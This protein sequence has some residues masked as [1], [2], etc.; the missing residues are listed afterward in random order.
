MNTPVL[1]VSLLGHL[2]LISVIE[3]YWSHLVKEGPGRWQN[4]FK[5]LCDLGLFN[6][7]DPVQ[8]DCIRFVS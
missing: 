6:D 2:H 4:V 5:D 7:A 3:A 1:Q 8:V